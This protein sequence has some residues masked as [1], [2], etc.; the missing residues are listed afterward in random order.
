MARLPLNLKRTDLLI[1]V[2]AA[3]LYV[4]LS[5][6]GFEPFEALEELIYG[7]E[8]RLDVP[9]NLG[10][11]R[12]AI[13][14]I[15]EKSFQ[16]LGSWPWPR[17]I[18]AEMISIL[19]GNGAKLIGLELLFSEEAQSQGLREI[20]AL[21]KEIVQREQLSADPWLV[22]TVAGIEERLDNDRRLT[23]AV[24]A[25][26]NI[27][28]PVVGEFGRYETDLVLD[29][30]SFLKRNSI[31][32]PELKPELKSLIAVNRLITPFK[33]LSE[34]SRGLGH[35][36]LSP[37]TFMRGRVHLPFIDFR[38]RIIPSMPFRIASDY[39]DRMPE[40]VL[41]ASPLMSLG[42]EIF[43]KFKGAKRSFPYYSF[44]DILSVKKVPAV[45][46]GKIV[47][48]GYTAQDAPSINT[49]VDPRMP[50]VEFMANII[51]N[52]MNQRF[53]TRPSGTIYVES[54][55]LILFCGLASVASPRVTP[56]SR[57]G[58][59]AALAFLV[60]LIG[61]TSFLAFDVWLKTVYIVL[62]L[63][64]IYAAYTIKDIIISQKSLDLRSKESIETN[65]MLGLSFQSQGL[66]DLAF[67]K[68]RKCPLDDAMKDVVYNLGLDYERKRMTNK[69]IAVYEY[70]TRKEGGF[71]DLDQ[72][73]PKLKEMIGPLA[74]G[75]YEGKKE[76]RIALSADLETKPTV[77]RYE[78]LQELGQGAMGVVYKARDPRINRLLAIKTIRFSDEFEDE[79]LKEVR[80]R[81]LREAEIAGK[82]SHPSIVAIYDL[83]EDYDLTYLAMELLE[84]EDLQEHCRQGSLLP[85]KKVLHVVAATAAALDYAHSQGVIHRDVKPGNIM[86]LR[87]GTVKVTDFGIAKAMSDSKTKSGIILGT[88]NYMSPEQIN[89]QE[90]DGRSDIFSLGVVFY[91]LLT[92][93]LPFYGK[94]L[95][96]LFYQI[97]HAEP[98]PIREVNPR[99]PKPVV[100][101]VT[102]A[103]SKDPDR[104]FQRA[105]DL[106]RYVR[107]VLHKMEELQARARA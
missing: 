34:N 15:D 6:G 86:L 71:R 84:G 49:P 2:M 41:A 80:D 52:L 10:A 16:R 44:A 67:E 18:I 61:L 51:E 30:D 9:E 102:K 65:R 39:L 29:E 38:G 97:T 72:R 13:V 101:I 91:E 92:G 25:C 64:T 46:D 53:I 81:F 56:L 74:L 33:E 27:I 50:R 5:L 94:T 70:I 99:V 11:S 23:E 17:H 4:C 62:A 3:V 76:D 58:V 95:T 90:I 45:F 20:R 69:A 79:K 12:I 42:G 48:I 78:V 1:G 77:G 19:K 106:A 43:V 75:G 54:L 40:D 93:A 59:T 32:I 7:I 55:L 57:L 63:G 83:G 37:N 96:N 8:M 87:N 73:I 26:G 82:L 36:N 100:Q 24:S 31:T 107:V 47:L 85:L 89:G 21:R 104:R 60:F 103:L 14:N 66:L 22:E 35:L 98:H 105:G 28:L 68:F 88:P